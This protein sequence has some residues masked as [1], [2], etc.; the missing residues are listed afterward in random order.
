[1]KKTAIEVEVI[2]KID[3]IPQ[4]TWND[5]HQSDYPFIQHQFLAALERHHCVSPG[6]GWLPR[7]L[8]FRQNGLIIAALPLYEKH[9]NYGEFVFDQ[10]WQQAWESVKLPYYPKLVSAVPYTP[11]KGP[12]I[13]IRPEFRQDPQL[14]AE[15]IET[16]KKLT[17]D[18]Q[19]S[20]FHLLFSDE[21]NRL[22]GQNEILCRHDVQ[23]QWFNQNYNDFEE[24][25][26]ALKSKKR[27]NIRQERKVIAEQGIHFRR[28]SGDQASDQD[29]RDFDFFYQKTFIEKWSTPTL[30]YGFFKEIAETMPQN[31]LLVLAERD[32][33]TLA[34]A[35]MFRSDKVL[36]G[37]HWGCAENIK[38]LHFETC[39]Y[40][41]IDYAI[42]QGLQRFE[43][44]A[45]GEHKI[46]RGFVPVA[47]QSSHWLSI[48]PFVEGVERFL[49]EE[50]Q[51]M[52]EYSRD[53]WQSA[54]YQDSDRIRQISEN[55]PKIA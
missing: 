14:F 24:F 7:H 11:A 8:I 43:P 45:G 10:S 5:L 33:E 19:Y 32:G 6:L 41:G 2:E 15:I 21:Q 12:R 16:L 29:W 31:I 47:M 30:N 1:M 52:S 28:L 13:L 4:Q 48:N 17:A 50:K 20:G 23:F 9:N 34:G 26:D 55:A 3:W 44:G 51:L 40:Q 36:Y 18:N 49:H 27:K 35:L 37:R 38:H 53:A 22:A 39:F 54:P 42:Q 46:A 25:L